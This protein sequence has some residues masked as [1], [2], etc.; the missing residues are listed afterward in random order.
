[1]SEFWPPKH[2]TAWHC[3]TCRDI[4][5]ATRDDTCNCQELHR[6]AN[7]ALNRYWKRTCARSK[8]LRMEQH[9]P[10]DDVRGP[11]VHTNNTTSRLATP[12]SETNTMAIHSPAAQPDPV[13]PRTSTE[14]TPP[15]LQTPTRH[16]LA[17]S[18][19]ATFTFD[20]STS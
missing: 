14:H 16:R 5:T 9:T 4:S 11:A 3:Q 13:F 1:M 2:A 10:D 8:G 17:L 19:L 6:T 7:R 20:P 18:P 12:H 15:S